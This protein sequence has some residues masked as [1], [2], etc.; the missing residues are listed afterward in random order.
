MS[1]AYMPIDG[2]L[3]F[4][5]VFT[6]DASAPEFSVLPAGTYPFVIE[7]IERDHVSTDP[8]P[9]GTTSTYAGCP[10][11]KVTFRL[12]GKDA[13]GEDVEVH[14]TENFILHTKF[15][16]KISQLFI[17]VGL[18]KQG[19]QFRPDWQ[20]LPTRTGQCDVSIRKFKKRDGS[21]GESNQID[22][23]LDPATV[24]TVGPTAPAW[25]SGF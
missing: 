2:A 3:D 4:D 15:I 9:D 5:S 23:Y 19:E 8:R 12:N 10:M 17:S 25:K 1:E 22:K 18:A 13:S 7:K 16:W 11:A 14:R 6:A 21:D 20:A 24:A